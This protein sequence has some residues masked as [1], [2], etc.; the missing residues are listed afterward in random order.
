[1]CPALFVVTKAAYLSGEVWLLSPF[2]FVLFVIAAVV[3]KS[4]GT[5]SRLVPVAQGSSGIRSD[6]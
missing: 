4:S 5:W 6:W 2:L 1:M 3:M